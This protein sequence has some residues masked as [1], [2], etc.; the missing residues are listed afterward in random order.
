MLETAARV[1][2]LYTLPQRQ[3]GK[4]SI[5]ERMQMT[6]QMSCL[7]TRQN[8]EVVMVAIYLGNI[9]LHTLSPCFD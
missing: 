7:C 6:S 4:P 1:E 9:V 2:D 5:T 8:S 3:M